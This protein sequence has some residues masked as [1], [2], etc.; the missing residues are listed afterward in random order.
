M[1]VKKDVPWKKPD[2]VDMKSEFNMGLKDIERLDKI[3]TR[4]DNYALACGEGDFKMLIPYINGLRGMYRYF[5][6][7][8]KKETKQSYEK[9][10]DR[11]YN[12]IYKQKQFTWDTYRQIDKLHLL[13]MQTRQDLKL[14]IPAEIRTYG[15][16]DRAMKP[17]HRGDLTDAVYTGDLEKDYGDD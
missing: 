14:G 3:L 1:A 11:L 7:L 12:L 5:Q 17:E 2:F 13:L 15:P 4:V 10:F 6:A 9:A 8:M 16:V